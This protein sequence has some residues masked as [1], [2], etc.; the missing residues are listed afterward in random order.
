MKLSIARSTLLGMLQKV[1]GVVENRQTLPILANVLIRCA[2]NRFSLTASDLEMELTAETELPLSD[3]SERFAFTAAARKLLEICQSL[4]DGCTVNLHLDGDKLRLHSDKASF[5]LAT[6]P[7]D[8]FPKFEVPA[9]EDRILVDSA[10][11]RRT[12]DQSR[13][14]MAL[15]DVRFY[16]NGL[17]LDVEG[18]MLRLVSADGHRLAYA[19]Q[20]L[21][22]TV[23]ARRQMI[24]PRKGVVEL[25]RLLGSFTGDVE[26][27]IGGNTLR[28]L[29]GNAVFSVKLIDATYPDYRRLIPSDLSRTIMVDKGA[30]KQSLGSVSVLCHEKFKN[31]RFDFSPGL[32]SLSATNS[33]NEEASDVVDINFDGVPLLTAY[34]GSYIMEALNHCDG[35]KVLFGIDDRGVCV[36]E[37]ETDAG[38]RFVVMPLRT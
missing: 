37:A 28:A 31:V 6:L 8:N 29:L 22:S 23:T 3:G 26:I 4:A 24:L 12:I 35:D 18:D 16:L 2:D 38:S 13:F 33:E 1:I 19:E 14:A 15:Q 5:S 34:N 21:D 10:K 27:G 17:L 25:H 9:I 11:L 20:R 32:L 7:A 30:L 36:I